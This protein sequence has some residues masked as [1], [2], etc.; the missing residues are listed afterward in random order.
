MKSSAFFAVF[1]RQLRFWSFHC[2]VNAAPSF[3]IALLWLQLSENPAAILAMLCGIGSFILLY[4][5]LT[6]LPGP[7]SDERN[8]LSR[9]LKAG[10]KIRSWI[11]GLSFLSVFTPALA[12]SPDFWCGNIAVKMVESLIR[13]F[14]SGFS[15]ARM[16]HAGFLKIY[17]TT[18]I[19]GCF[20]SILLLMISFFAVIVLQSKER[21][22][23]LR[24]ARFHSEIAR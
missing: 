4:A 12:I 2:I 5:A 13:T 11:A 24:S 19:E 8:I 9:S 20:L 15:V 6:S 22:K 14:R 10:A 3:A 21:R 23:F 7:L 16:E 18:V 17:L 1:P